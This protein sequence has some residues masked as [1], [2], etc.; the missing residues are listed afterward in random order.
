MADLMGDGF[1]EQVRAFFEENERRTREMMSQVGAQ[2]EAQQKFIKDA[3]DSQLA[4]QR[5]AISDALERSSAKQI[6]D[7]LAD[8]WRAAMK[9]AGEVAETGIKEAMKA[10]ERERERQQQAFKKLLEDMPSLRP[11]PGQNKPSD[12]AK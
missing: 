5:K 1:S 10:L 3:L 9:K 6:G 12:D 4:G 8:D 2:L 7:R 11:K